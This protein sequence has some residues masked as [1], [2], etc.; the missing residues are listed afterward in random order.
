MLRSSSLFGILFALTLAACGGTDD[1]GGSPSGGGSGG[2]SASGGSGGVAGGGGVAGASGGAG[3]GA[4]APWMGVYSTEL[5]LPKASTP[6]INVDPGTVFYADVPYGSDPAT[7]FDI[8]VPKSSGPTPLMIHI[9]GGGFVGGTKSSYSGSAAEIAA[10]LSKGVAYASLEYRLLDEVD[11]VGVIK[12]MTDCRRALQ[13]IRHHAAAFNIAPAKVLLEGGSAGA[14][15][16][17]WIAFSDDMAEPGNSDPVAQQSTRV[18][19]VAANSTQATYDVL[20]WESVVFKEYGLPLLDLAVQAGMGQRLMSF[21]GVDSVDAMKTPAIT[22]YRARVDMLALMSADDPPFYVNNPLT[23]AAPPLD[24]NSLFHHA[25]HARTLSE[26]AD[27]IGLS[28]LT[29]IKALSVAD[30]SGTDDWGFA[31]QLLTK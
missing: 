11:T 17:L 28:H 20:K 30:A 13:F 29:Y 25:F 10:L 31:L 19:G 1:S 4:G 26:Q 2:S 7:R 3:G 21:Y 27:K 22:E 9:H 18:L 23:P 5:E 15:T 16:S 12:P 14:G 6:P 8:F 24:T